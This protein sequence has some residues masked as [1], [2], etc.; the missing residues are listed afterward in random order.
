MSVTATEERAMKKWTI[1]LYG[2]LS[3]VIFLATLLYTIGFVGNLWVG[4]SIDSAPVV[5]V[6]HALLLNLALLAVFAVQH[7][8]MAR[9]FFKGWLL[10]LLPQS[11][12]RSTYVL[13]SCLAL[14]LLVWGWQPMGGI[15]W[16]L[17]ATAAAKLA[18]AVFAAGWV[19]VL[20]STFQIDHFDLFGLR[21]VWLQLR[22]RRYTPPRFSTPWL[23][24]HVRHPLY[25][26]FFLALWATPTMSAAHLVFALMCTGYIM[27]G[28]WLEERDLRNA[29]PEYD[30]YAR[31]VP[32]Y[33]PKF[34]A[35]AVPEQRA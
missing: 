3:Y 15:V 22:G 30:E 34:G 16:D 11:A 28:T 27:V 2:G 21:Q 33:L 17:A 19:L 35:R 13:A 18:Y 9:P 14:I 31:T 10:R 8:L 20:I 6:G 26:G 7:S 24:R 32:R 1:F 12:E 4:K 23:Y 29:H 25:L 5:T